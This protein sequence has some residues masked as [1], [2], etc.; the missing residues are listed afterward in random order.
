MWL[1]T[2]ISIIS[3]FYPR[4][5]TLDTPELTLSIFNHQIIARTISIRSENAISRFQQLCNDMRLAP[6]SQLFFCGLDKTHYC[7]LTYNKI[8]HLSGLIYSAKSIHFLQPHINRL[9]DN[10]VYEAETLHLP[11]YDTIRVQI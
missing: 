10:M 1:Q 3:S 2:Y 5:L 4:S 11:G 8:I 9:C 6:L 7:H